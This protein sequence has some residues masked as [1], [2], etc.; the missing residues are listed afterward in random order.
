MQAKTRAVARTFSFPSDLSLSLDDFALKL[1][2]PVS[3]VVARAVKEYIARE[4]QILL[5]SMGEKEVSN[6]G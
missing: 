2:R 3:Y 5:K 1:E 6:D 4:N